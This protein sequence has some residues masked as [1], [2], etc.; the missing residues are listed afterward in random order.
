MCL[1]EYQRTEG[2]IPKGDFLTQPGFLIMAPCCHFRRIRY[3]SIIHQVHIQLFMNTKLKSSA[4][5]AFESC[6]TLCDPMDCSPPGSSIH[7]ILQARILEWVAISFSRGSS[8]PR[9]QTQV[10][11][12]AGRNFNL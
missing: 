11:C 2:Q 4:V 12:I 9:D 5:F 8:Q 6:P 10:S 3:C 1:H 7:G